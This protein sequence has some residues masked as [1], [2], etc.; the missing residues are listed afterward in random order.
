VLL[1]GSGED[2]LVGSTVDLGQATLE[3]GKYIERCVMVTRAQPGGIERDLG[4]LRTIARERQNRLAIG[5]LV[6]R[7]GTVR[8]GDNLKTKG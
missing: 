5:A 4:V 7:P 8:V 1:E 2:E 6:S 3:I